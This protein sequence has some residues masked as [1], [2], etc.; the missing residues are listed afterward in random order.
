VYALRGTKSSASYDHSR[1]L[2]AGQKM[3]KGSKPDE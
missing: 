1:A 2:G 3:A